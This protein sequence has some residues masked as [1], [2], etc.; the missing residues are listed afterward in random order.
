VGDYFQISGY[1]CFQRDFE[2]GVVIV[3][4]SDSGCHVELGVPCVDMDGREVSSMTF[5]A[6][7]GMVFLARDTAG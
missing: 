2:K 4:P 5:S 1:D 7:E 6:R 3:N